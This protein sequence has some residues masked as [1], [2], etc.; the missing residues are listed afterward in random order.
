MTD[1]ERLSLSR[2]KAEGAATE[3]RSM[4]VD[5]VSE[6]SYLGS[7]GLG[8]VLRT[9]VSVES[10]GN[11]RIVTLALKRYRNREGKNEDWNALLTRVENVYNHVKEA[12]VP[13]F[14]TYRMDKEK[15]IIAMTDW[16]ENG[17]YSIADF[18]HKEDDSAKLE[19]ISNFESLA[20]GVFEAAR[21]VAGAGFWMDSGDPYFF[22]YL[23]GDKDGSVDFV[24]GDLDGMH[25]ESRFYDRSSFSKYQDMDRG[26]TNI[27]LKNLASAAQAL[28]WWLELEFGSNKDMYH[29]YRAVASGIYQKELIR[30]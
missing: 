17:K 22:R 8:E 30:Q 15:G 11:E 3:P 19:S 14:P 27:L 4:D 20:E 6:G 7:G 18:R 5:L 28:S 25:E 23:K 1:R 9:P 24:V 12:G 2:T 16:S 10:N 13:V 29:K 26:H 21:K